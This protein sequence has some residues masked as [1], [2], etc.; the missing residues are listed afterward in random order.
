[1]EGRRTRASGY[2][3]NNM[4]LSS[5]VALPSPQTNKY[6]LRIYACTY[7]R[8]HVQIHMYGRIMQRREKASRIQARNKMIQQIYHEEGNYALIYWISRFPSSFLIN[9]TIRI[10][11]SMATVGM[12][13]KTQLPKP[14]N[15]NQKGNWNCELG[16]QCMHLNM[17]H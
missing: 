15:G 6:G 17:N 11:R 16:T 1:M 14:A 3:S 12:L 13:Q 10:V 5:R 9:E 2:I 7:V 8:T 4:R